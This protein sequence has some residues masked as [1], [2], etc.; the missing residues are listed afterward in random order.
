MGRAKLRQSR[1]AGAWPGTNKY[2]YIDFELELSPPAADCNRYDAPNPFLAGLTDKNQELG[3]MFELQK[4]ALHNR[5]SAAHI[6]DIILGLSGGLDSTL[7]FL[8]AA[9]TARENGYTLHVL[10]MPCFGTSRQTKSNAQR[11]AEAAQVQFQELDITQ[12]AIDQLALIGH[13]VVGDVTYENVQARQ[14]TMILLNK[15]NQLNALVLGTAD[16]SE[17]ALGFCTYGG[18]HLSMYNINAS[19]PKTLV[20]ELVLWYAAQ[21]EPNSAAILRAIVAT[22]ISP[23][24]LPTDVQGNI[25]QSTEQ[26]VGSYE[27]I[28]YI[29]YYHVHCQFSQAKIAFLAQKVFGKTHGEAEVRKALDNYFGRFYR[30]QFKRTCAPDGAKVTEISLSPR[31]SWRMPADL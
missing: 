12:A 3:E 18:D 13:Q 25:A 4:K 21:A 1:L 8:V 14:R 27:I 24:L 16:L 2:L 22:P 5:L 10:S 26:I 15:A 19:I 31:S 6:N 28:D 9:E 7:A 11:L 20:R 23:E 29:L 17:T 30:N